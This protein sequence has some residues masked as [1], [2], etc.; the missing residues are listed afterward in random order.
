MECS[1]CGKQIELK[2]SIHTELE[3]K[4]I[5]I[6]YQWWECKSCGKKYFAT[7]EDSK[8]NIFDDTL[9]HSGYEADEADWKESLKWARKCPK[10]RDVNCNCAVH[11]EIPLSSFH[12]NSAWY[13]NG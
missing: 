9:T 10:P 7:L 4:P 2:L 11:K 12:G 13:T 5:E 6:H 8:V 1:Q 3:D